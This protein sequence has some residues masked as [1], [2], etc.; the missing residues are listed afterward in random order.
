MKSVNMSPEKR[1]SVLVVEDDIASMQYLLLLLKKLEYE[2]YSAET[3]E[4][5]L[6]LMQDKSVD[7]MLL[8]L[9][10][11]AGI[12]GIE[13]AVIL[14]KEKRFSATP[15]I[16]VSAFSKDKFRKLKSAGFSDYL[17]KPF[18]ISQLKVLL[19]QY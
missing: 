18:T 12:S 13:L 14:K 8:D 16:A 6:I 9:A 19:S 11:G 15:M 4:E 17:A 3:G 7:V 1:S 2:I 5:A 10:L